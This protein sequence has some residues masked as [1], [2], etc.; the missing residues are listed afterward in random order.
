MAKNLAGEFAGAALKERK[1]PAVKLHKA[2]AALVTNL[3]PLF[4]W[5][6][7]GG[8]VHAE[9]VMLAAAATLD[10][11]LTAEFCA[12]HDLDPRQIGDTILKSPAGERA[13]LSEAEC[14]LHD[15]LV[16]EV[17]CAVLAAGEH[18]KGFQ[19]ASK[20]ELL[21]RQRELGRRIEEAVRSLGDVG[22]SVQRTEKI[23]TRLEGAD[24]ERGREFEKKYRQAVTDTLN[25]ME[26]FGVGLPDDSPLRK[27]ELSTAYIS[28]NLTS[29]D[30]RNLSA[31]TAFGQV[32]DKL[33][34]DDTGNLL[35][36][37]DAG[38]GTSTLL[39]WAAIEAARSAGWM[40]VQTFTD[41]RQLRGARVGEVR[42]KGALAKAVLERFR[43]NWSA[44][45]EAADFVREWVSRMPFLILLR[46]CVEG[47]L[48]KPCQ[49]PGCISTA[50]GDP[51]PGWVE[52]IL[53]QGRALVLIDGID[54]VP[55][56]HRQGVYKGIEDL[57]RTYQKRGNVIVIST[58]PLV[59]DPGWVRRFGFREARIAPLSETDRNDLI[60]A[61]HGTVAEA[62]RDGG[63][64]GR[65][66]AL[67]Q[68]AAL[69][70]ERLSANP[71]VAQ[72]AS[73]PLLCALICALCGQHNYE[74]PRTQ[75]LIVEKL[76][77]ILLYQREQE[78][79]GQAKLAQ[80]AEEYRTL[81]YEQRKAILARLA[82]EMIDENA[83]VMAREDVERIVAE[84]ISRIRRPAEQARTILDVL[85]ERGGMIR[86][87]KAG[88]ID[89]V[90]N[91]FKEF[92]AA[93]Y[94]LL[95]N[96]TNHLAKE[97]LRADCRNVCLF[98]AGLQQA[99]KYV[100][101]LIGAI[102]PAGTVR[103]GRASGKGRR[104]RRAE[105]E[106][107]LLAV[108]MR[109]VAVTL[110]PDLHKRIDE[111]EKEL[112]P[113]RTF[114][115][116]EALA[117]LGE[118]VVERLRRRLRMSRQRM[119]ACVRALRLIKTA[120]AV[121]ALREYST[122]ATDMGLIG[123]LAQ[124]MNPLEIP[125]VLA[126]LT[127]E[128][129]GWSLGDDWVP[130]SVR[131]QVDDLGPLQARL[132]ASHLDLAS[133]RV[134]DLQL[135]GRMQ[136]LTTLDA[137]NCAGVDERGLAE[138]AKC[139]AL[140][141]LDVSNCDGVNERGL[142]KLAKCRALTTLDAP[143]CAAVNKRGLAELAKCP[144]LTRLNVSGC[145]G[146][147]QCGLAELAKWPAL[148]TLDV[149]ACH[150]VSERGLAELAKCPALIKLNVSMCD[151][152]NERGLAELAKC[153]ALTTLD[154]WACDG[155]NE[156]GLAEL[157]KCPTLTTL[158]VS[159]CE[160]VNERGLAAL[161]K[162]R[163]LTTLDVSVCAGV[164]E[165]ALAELARHPTLTTLSVH[166]CPGVNERGLKALASSRSLRRVI[167][168]S[169]RAA[170]TLRRL[171]P[172]WEVG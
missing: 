84:E 65:A 33:A 109:G 144:A 55:A 82:W 85:L 53:E 104:A 26:L 20:A 136:A 139:P 165:R 114:A 161:A 29:E 57:L 167:L 128:A 36:R 41:V 98:A 172:D 159:L 67:L 63:H 32:L 4:Q 95:W 115:A 10:G 76:C 102:L 43:T 131:R 44:T 108:R 42:L 156:R 7:E 2:L 48:P 18:L 83:P 137:S 133:T 122:D 68:K 8:T 160:G 145:T 124:A 93:G 112:I 71:P 61:W 27:Q 22:V 38:S 149:S 103:R 66:E 3:E 78:S 106:R 35:V 164:N 6:V 51:P 46:E 47:R 127:S 25:E 166:Q 39:K 152:V 110:E 125:L 105:L 141:T 99:E 56:K 31:P 113:P 147:D 92:V 123:E 30:G 40:L 86:P 28:L 142:A 169:A 89:F 132:D 116:A 17:V 129:P 118:E 126:R 157:A 100:T 121:S 1:K 171:R 130:E 5:E 91:T 69:L 62:L 158:D 135:L 19:I 23:V 140:T 163:M 50:I 15:R 87:T 155:V 119:V 134:T 60:D 16:R 150:G 34:L 107:A 74:L 14:S 54:E 21:K 77:E 45:F 146:V 11:Q 117:T 72:L 111:L 37:G 162:C 79:L 52:N 88:A 81:T 138:L 101:R 13:A 148:T 120:R 75:V 151:A 24:A 143:N 97:A 12:A 170:A 59:D 94:C 73:T 168:A 70:K 80:V 96:K 153:P 49:Y 90:H 154:A 9:P 64:A 58:R